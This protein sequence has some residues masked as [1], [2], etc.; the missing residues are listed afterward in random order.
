V[1]GLYRRLFPA[2][3]FPSEQ[4]SEFRRWHHTH[5]R[6]QVRRNLWAPLSMLLLAVYAPGPFAT[7]REL[8]LGSQPILAT[9]VICFAVLGP[10]ALAL[11]V[12]AYS[13][14]Y[15][16]FYRAAANLIVPLQ[17]CCFV[18]LD[19]AVRPQGFALSTW[20]VL[21]VIGPYFMFGLSHKAA[22]RTGLLVI[23]SYGAIGYFGG[24]D[25]GQWRLD[26]AVMCFASYLAASIHFSLQKS[27]RRTYLDTRRLSESAHRDGLTGIYN[28]RMFDEH[29]GRVWQQATR[30]CV[31]LALL[32]IDVDCFKLFNDARG[33][34]AGD[35][36]L[37][38]LAQV[39][40]RAA[41]RP[42]DLAARYGGEEFA[43]LLYGLER[44]SVEELCRQLQ[45]DV[46]QLAIE[47]PASS[48]SR[49]VTTSVG[50][51]CV[52]PTT[53]RTVSGFIQ[54]ADEALYTAKEAGRN[55]M[56]IMDREYEDL[57]TGAFRHGGVRRSA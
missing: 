37:R 7:F 18:A 24:L 38:R 11:L 19:V 54:L 53:Y 12:I 15:Q 14:L 21:V 34:Q 47:H 52:Q 25:G 36:C 9:R 23:C 10:A 26:F 50:A 13:R 48:V 55:R 29:I 42:L 56:H 39:I 57:T 17:A 3:R 33:H 44:S 8:I 27:M 30:A 22:I 32:I 51:A 5:T 28:R 20:M 40:A 46:A 6:A 49:I 45:A 16:R 4:E 35:D 41:R 1:R 31:P 2:L 43:V